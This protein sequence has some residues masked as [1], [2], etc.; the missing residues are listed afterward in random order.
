M[1]SAAL[2]FENNYLK[3]NNFT[4]HQKDIH[5]NTSFDLEVC[6]NS[7]CGI[8][9]CEYDIEQFKAFISAL[10]EMY[11]FQKQVVTLN[12]ICYGSSVKF[13][14]D[15]TGHIVV[16]GRIFGE[17]MIHSLEFSFDA[18][19]TVLNRFILELQELIV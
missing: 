16:E 17:A 14:A 13:E 9:P 19:Q 6:S 7:F 18:D 8:A 3:I 12:D 1:K 5:Y 4:Y 10:H 11:D 2:I 15:K